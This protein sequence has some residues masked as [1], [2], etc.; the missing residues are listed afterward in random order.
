MKDIGK[1]ENSTFWRCSDPSIERYIK[2]APKRYIPTLRGRFSVI[3]FKPINSKR[4]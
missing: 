2:C 1:K 3:T 4:C